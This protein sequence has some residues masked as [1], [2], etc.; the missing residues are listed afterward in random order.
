MYAPG[1]AEVRRFSRRLVIL[2]TPTVVARLE[3]LA[4]RAGHSTSAEVRSAIRLWLRS[5]DGLDDR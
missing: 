3:Q 5:V 4:E 2:E 1:D